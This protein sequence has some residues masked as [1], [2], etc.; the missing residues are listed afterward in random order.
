MLSL[1]SSETKNKL[2]FKFLAPLFYRYHIL[3]LTIV[4]G[5]SFPKKVLPG[6]WSVRVPPVP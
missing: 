2:I 6:P 1:Q 5:F 3:H 4:S